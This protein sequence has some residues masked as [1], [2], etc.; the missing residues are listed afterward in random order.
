LGL[1]FPLP[2]PNLHRMDCMFLRN[3]TDGLHPSQGFNTDLGLELRQVH[4]AF[5]L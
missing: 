5:L 4:V 2:L 1:Y 3:L